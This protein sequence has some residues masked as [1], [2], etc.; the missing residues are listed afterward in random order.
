MRRNVAELPEVLRLEHRLGAR[1][2]LISNVYP[3]TP[4]LLREILFRRS[5]GESPW[6][7]S[8]IRLGRMDRMPETAGILD[9]VVNGLYGARLE[10]LELLWPADTCPFVSR[11]STCVRWDG[12]VSP[13]LPLLHTHVSYLENRPR[14]NTAFSLG[15]VIE[16]DLPAL[17]E[18]PEYVALRRRLEAFD[19]STC[20]ACNSCEMAGGN[21]EDCFGNSL[22]AC[23]GC[24]WAQGFIQCP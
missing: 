24:L 12:R 16:H 23:G 5:I 11:G 14:S 15:S 9:T 8:Q 7:R 22:P 13:C 4:E 3:H 20:T 19:F 17:W 10:G 18:S 21:Q 1:K 2:F 6:S